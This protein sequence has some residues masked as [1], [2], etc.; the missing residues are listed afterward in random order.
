MTDE[1]NEPNDVNE[2]VDE[3]EGS[4]RTVDPK[5]YEQVANDMHKYKREL[6]D[7]QSKAKDY[8]QKLKDIDLQKLEQAEKHKE[9][10]DHYKKE[11]E[12]YKGKYSQTVESIITDR[13]LTAVER[14]L[15]K[16]SI[17]PEFLD[18]AL[19]MID[20]D[21]IVEATSTGRHNVLGADKFVERLRAER[22]K[23]FI[24]PKAPN[25]NNSTGSYKQ[26]G[27]ISAKDLVKLQKENPQEYLRVRKEMMNKR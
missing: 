7:W 6:K 2:Q 9:V 15:S 24:D 18:I 5:A 16:A 13:K 4:T 12:E 25:I 3:R 14:E 20:D 22:P 26:S 1:V 21:V 17:D 23:M 27:Q 10:A 19:G 8:E 11:L